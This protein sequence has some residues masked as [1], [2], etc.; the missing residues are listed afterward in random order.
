MTITSTTAAP[1][2]VIVV[3]ARAA[4]AV[5]PSIAA[6][7]GSLGLAVHPAADTGAAVRTFDALTRRGGEVAVFVLAPSLDAPVAA[8]R[9]LFG[10]APSIH[11]VFVLDGPANGPVRRELALAP[12]I[13]TGWTT[14]SDDG[15]AV[16]SALHDA[17]RATR[18][19]VRSRTTL[20]RARTQLAPRDAARDD[21]DAGVS[22]D[23]RRR[24]RLE[25]T[26]A[27][28]D[29]PDLAAAAPRIL[30]AL[31]SALGWCAAALWMLDAVTNRLRCAEVWRADPR[32]LGDFAAATRTLVLGPGEGWPGLAWLDRRPRMVA[33]FATDDRDPRAAV[34]AREDL[35]T[36]Y[37]Q[38][39]LLGDRALG[40]I[41]LVGRTRRTL[42]AELE[43]MM[44]SAA[45]SIAQL[46]ERNRIER[47][48][49]L[50]NEE[51]V[52][53][54]RRKNEQ[55]AMLSHELRNPLAPIATAVAILQD[56]DTAPATRAHGLAVIERQVATLA[57]LVDDLL[58]VSRISTGMLQIVCERIAI[59]AVIGRALETARPSI[60]RAGLTLTVA[61]PSE[62]LW[63]DADPVR[64]AQVLTNLLGN[65]A[66]YTD[67]GGRV[68]LTASPVGGPGARR[69]MIAVRDT[70]IGIA[71]DLQA[72]VFDLFA[73]GPA[74]RLR[75][76]GGLGIGLTLVKRLV[77]LHGGEVGVTSA[78]ANKGSE[79]TVRLPLA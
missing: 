32:A 20:A 47:A 40:V 38:P 14:A 17:V 7:A 11:M 3:G 29:E 45:T 52:A 36:A 5:P 65:A 6:A 49:R 15:D 69:V 63:L 25:V 8:A 53:A 42:D 62:P 13:G 68:W 1:P 34:A 9:R 27:L 33:D 22:P 72:H 60:D 10:A 35:H 48:L 76:R 16:T 4:E 78:G 77:E 73:Q 75:N 18:H 43:E 61:V 64:L 55:L 50:H 70:G 46:A 67:R 51:L 28:V 79:F 37:F 19:R 23:D 21:L 44:A 39:I 30:A 66:K 54:D 24:A 58:D 56:E 31:G 2:S 71:A 59:G 12:R 57:R 26:Q 41:E 74:S